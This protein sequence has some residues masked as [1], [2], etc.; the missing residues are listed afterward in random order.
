MRRI[1][2]SLLA[3]SLLVLV[4][5]NRSSDASLVAKSR[6]VFGP[7]P[8]P[9]AARGDTPQLV[10]LGRELYF[11]NEL[12][13]TR[14]QSCAS[15][16]PLDGTRPGADRRP[17]SPGAH[18]QLGRRNSPTVLNT[19][20]HFA[21]FWD[22]RARTLEEQAAGPM[23]N[24]VEMA[25]P[26][27]AAIADRLRH[28]SSINP[29]LFLAAFPNDPDPFSVDHAAR[30]IAAFERTLRTHDRFDDFQNG[31]TRALSREEKFGLSRFMALGC[32]SCHNG[33][34][35]GARQFQRIGIVNPY[36]TS[37]HGREEL[38]R[39]PSDDFVFKVPSLR[40]VALTPPYFHDGKVRDLPTAVEKMAW[41]QLGIKIKP[42][43][44]DAIVAFLRSLSD[45]KRGG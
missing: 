13:V 20:L 11:S 7:L 37:D 21:L 19:D 6:R 5:C 10:R 15:C 28:A 40:N 27:A 30:A 26:N 1:A 29:A 9:T 18:G 17:T 39:N 12:S 34:T 42:Q 43:D 41:H 35:I 14:K 16:H 44:R 3:A 38:T 45:V 33:P 24:P 36:P 23:M 25:M 4:S 31:N 2:R 32:T 8:Q 22:G